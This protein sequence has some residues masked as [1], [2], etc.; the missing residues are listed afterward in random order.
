MLVSITF[1]VEHDCPPYLTTTRGMEDGLPKLLDLMAEKRVK[2]TFFFTA[3]MARRFPELVKR[4]IDEGHELG[5]HNYN[6]ERLDRLTRAEGERAIVKSLK[7]LREFGE[8]LS[9]RAPNLQ[10]PDYYYGI[11]ERNG[12]LVDSSKATYK[13]YRMGVRFFGD[14]LEV[15]ASTTSSVIRLP[16]RAQKLIHAH[17]KEPRVYFAH[18]W[19]FVPMQREK[20]RWDCKFNTG[21]KAVELLGRL[22]DYYKSRNAKFLTMRD[23]L[24]LYG[25][26]TF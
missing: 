4:V 16:W 5:S 20:I 12:I 7:V 3:E 18:P 13:G 15:P 2:A 6:H 22:I 10:F 21:D 26:L 17:L 8:V 24:S 19:E 23:Y 14:V 1:D 9:F 25:G 11:L